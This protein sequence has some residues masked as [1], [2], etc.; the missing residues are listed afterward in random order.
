MD[1]VVWKSPNGQLLFISNI[2]N[3]FEYNKVSKLM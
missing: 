3:D 1:D 2:L